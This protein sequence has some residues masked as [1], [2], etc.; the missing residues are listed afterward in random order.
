MQKNQESHEIEDLLGMISSMHIVHR[1]TAVFEGKEKTRQCVTAVCY[2]FMLHSSVLHSSVLQLRV[3]RP[4]NLFRRAM[5]AC[6]SP[7]LGKTFATDLQSVTQIRISKCHV[8]SGKISS[9]SNATL[10][11]LGLC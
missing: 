6:P 3:T 2:S 11:L 5:W 9:K 8:P 1:S 4:K 7:V 10:Q